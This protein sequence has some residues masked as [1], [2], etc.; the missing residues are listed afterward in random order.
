MSEPFSVI[1][2]QFIRELVSQLRN[3]TTKERNSGQ[4]HIAGQARSSLT[5]M[6]LPETTNPVVKRSG[7]AHM[8]SIS[9][10]AASPGD[11]LDDWLQAERE[12]DGRA[13]QRGESTDI[14]AHK[15]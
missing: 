4:Y 14:E 8:K 12:V 13:P 7:S 2:G 5:Q 15:P 11:E 9:N 10:V 3:S 1:T 6:I